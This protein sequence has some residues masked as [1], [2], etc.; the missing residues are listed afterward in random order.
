VLVFPDL[1]SGNLVVN[2]AAVGAVE[3]ASLRRPE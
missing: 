2:L 3:A 1:Q